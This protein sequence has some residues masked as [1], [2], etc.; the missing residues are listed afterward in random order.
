M[1]DLS[2]SDSSFSC[3]KKTY[4][5]L[6]RYLGPHRGQFFWALV[7][8]VIYGSTDGIVPLLIRSILDDIFGHQNKDMLLLLPVAVV[9]FAIVRGLFGFLQRYLSA[10]VGLCVVEDIRNEINRHLLSLSPSFFLKHSTGSLITRMT[11]DTLLVR[12]ALTDAVAAIL[13]D[14]VR[15]VALMCTALYLDPVLALV[16]FIGFPLGIYPIVKYGKRIRRLSKTGQEQFGGLTAV[17][18]QSIG[19][20]KVVQSFG[21][22]DFEQLRFK[23]ENAV[24]TKTLLKAEKYGALSAPTNEMI[25]SVAI[26][27]VILYGGFSV[28]GGTRTQGDF[29]AFLMALFLLYE[30]FKKTSRINVMVQ[31]GVASAERIFEVLDTKPDIVDPA[32]INPSNVKN[33]DLTKVDI[34]F[35]DVWFYYPT[36]AKVQSD[37]TSD[38]LCLSEKWAL[39]GV[40]LKVPTGHTL[41]LVGMSGGGKSTLVSLLSR[42][43]DPNKGRVCING[44][45]I[46]DVSLSSLR[47]AVSVVDQHT[48]LFNDNV[49]NNI[50]YGNLNAS[51]EDVFNVAKAAYANEFIKNLPRGYDTVIGEQGF[52]LSGGERARIAIARALL[53]DAPILVMDEA[54]ASLDSESEQAVQKAIERLRKGRT[55]IV[56]AHRLATVQKADSIVT[57][58]NGQVVETGT[59]QELLNANGEYAK[60]YSIQFM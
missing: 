31:S 18:Q 43:Y 22:E 30:P 29:I 5:R 50:K 51:D 37:D 48:F 46:R 4:L 38:T 34:S 17:L 53:K 42:F 6:L 23:S 41:A 9:I 13:R 47:K 1:S 39:R 14:S 55:V 57:I 16:A 24:Y 36:D 58:V 3:R 19:G 11:N 15:I 35:E 59:H 28:I 26:A 45:D 2:K 27:G 40:S 60:L 20:H 54:T 12:T 21:Q 56:I 7:A 8:M 10:K 33:L 44:V 25:A 32:D 49:M 52:S